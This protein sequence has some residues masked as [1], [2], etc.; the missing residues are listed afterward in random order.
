MPGEPAWFFEDFGPVQAP[1]RL[2][3]KIEH[4]QRS[5]KG[6][7]Y[8]WPVQGVGIVQ[9]PLRARW[10]VGS[11]EPRADLSWAPHGPVRPTRLIVRVFSYCI[12]M[13]PNGTC[14]CTSWNSKGYTY[15]FLESCG[16]NVV[17]TR[18]EPIRCMH[19]TTKFRVLI[20]LWPKRH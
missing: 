16:Q 11:Y 2:C 13:G 4:K 7:L 6:F 17:R 3:L 9:V 10:S 8:F 5:Y 15:G 19:V 18:L 1:F 14:I 20:M 12:R